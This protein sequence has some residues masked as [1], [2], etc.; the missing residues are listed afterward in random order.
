MAALAALR[1]DAAAAGV[2]AGLAPRRRQPKRKLDPPGPPQQGLEGAGAP[3]PEQGRGVDAM[4]RKRSSGG[5]GLSACRQPKR[6]AG[7]GKPPMQGF[8][9]V[10]TVLPEQARSVAA[11]AHERSSGGGGSLMGACGQPM[12]SVSPRDPRL[13]CLGGAR[14][15]GD[16]PGLGV[17]GGCGGVAEVRCIVRRMHTT[18]P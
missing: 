6:K 2:I 13:Q 9:G 18:L 7:S 11:P 8:E 10:R 14:G 17:A 16:L 12:G 1:A 5:G 3:P 15:L 4:P